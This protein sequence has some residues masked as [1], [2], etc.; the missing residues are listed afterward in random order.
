M[1]QTLAVRYRPT[2]FRQMI[3]QSVNAAVL[4]KM[5]ETDNIPAGLIFSGVR[6]SGKTTAARILA[7][8]A[9]AGMPI[10]VDAASR[11]SVQDVRELLETL[12]FSTGGERR[13]VIYDEA[14]SMSKEAL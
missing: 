8:S 13:I 9:N 12:R 14:H 2:E 6:G 1:N 5:V 11:G 4:S 7:N 3:G 10:E